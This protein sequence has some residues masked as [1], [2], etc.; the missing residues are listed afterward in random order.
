MCTNG[1][2]GE[3]TGAAANRG[4]LTKQEAATLRLSMLTINAAGRFRWVKP[5]WTVHDCVFDEAAAKI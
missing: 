4:V 5:S 2:R 3:A 1:A